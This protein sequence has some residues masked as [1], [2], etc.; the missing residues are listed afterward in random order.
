[1]MVVSLHTFGAQGDGRTDDTAAVAAAFASGLPLLGG[2]PQ[3]VYL[4]KA[5]ILLTA[6]VDFDGQGCTLRPVG[7]TP[8]L[9][10]NGPEGAESTAVVAGAARGSRRI[11]V[12]RAAGISVGR[13]VWMTADDAPTHDSASYPDYWG[14]VTAVSG[15]S[16]EVDRPLPVDYSGRIR[17]NILAPEALIDHAVLR[18]VTFDGSACTSRATLGLGA[19]LGAFRRVLVEGCSFVD[20]NAAP[21]ETLALAIVSSL[22]ATIRDCRFAGQVSRNQQG[23][24]YYCRNALISGC[25]VDGSAFGLAIARSENATFSD[26]FLNGYRKREGDEGEVT[27]STRGIKAFGCA[28]AT[29]VNNCVSDYE[30]GIK[31]QACFRFNV[32][33]N[34]V[35]NSALSRSYDGGIA[36]NIGSI[37]RGVNMT[38]GIV[39]ENIVENSGGIGIG[40]TSDDPA[41]VIIVGNQVMVTQGCG[42]HANVRDVVITANHV[43]DWGLRRAADVGIIFG[44]GATV[45]GNRLSHSTLSNLACLHDGFQP[46]GRYV[47]RDNVSESGNPLG[48][49]LENSG[50]G[51][52]A[53]GSGRV[54]VTHG[55]SRTPG[56]DEIC[57]MPTSGLAESSRPLWVSDIGPR[58]FTLNCRVDPGAPGLGFF[59]RATIKQPFI[60]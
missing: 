5:P 33:G 41:R 53:A 16:V 6:S 30:S 60:A 47:V 54:S 22:D 11:V 17:L 35:R 56:A 12:E 52:I 3:F 13:W 1:M 32:R 25:S 39:A 27:R 58:T 38:G 51:R 40:V 18:N 8:A 37:R 59:W 49:V 7:D 55:L 23:G 14:K 57:V 43:S 20:F 28:S 31:V 24:I 9:V 36:L 50:Q 2:G 29:I 4:L 15:N 26:N 48:C 10:R 46:A 45:I 34:T 19:R 21:Q 42:I 44:G